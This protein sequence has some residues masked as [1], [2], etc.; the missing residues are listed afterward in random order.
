M[1]M[2]SRLMDASVACDLADLRPRQS[3]GLVRNGKVMKLLDNWQKTWNARSRPV[4]C[5]AVLTLAVVASFGA[6]AQTAE[7]PTRPVT[8]IVPYAAGGFTDI[9][10]RIASQYLSAKLGQSFMIENRPGAGGGIGTSYFVKT[11]PDGYTLMFGSA[12]QPGIAPFTR[13]ITYDPDDLMPVTIFGRIPFLLAV[14]SEFPAADV[15][16]LIAHAKTLNRGLNSAVTGSGTTSHLLSAS[17]AARAGIPVVNIPYKG[18][19]PVATAIVQGDVDI[20]WAGVSEIMPMV[21]GGKV[22]ALATSAGKRLPTLPN[23]PTVGETLAGFELQTWNGFF[24]SRDTPKPIIDKVSQLLREAV[25]TPEMAKRL[26][27]LGFDPAATTPEEMMQIIKTDKS[28]YA[29]AVK[30]AGLKP[31]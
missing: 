19:A 15:A 24:A 26:R 20:A 12:S 11:K 28:F 1:M 9:L 22:K 6:S 3:R 14:R 21:A 27:E 30:A 31:E 8:V 23:V 18:S 4:A 25:A 13:K 2:I 16:G 29:A 7:W 17:F 5:V 10:A